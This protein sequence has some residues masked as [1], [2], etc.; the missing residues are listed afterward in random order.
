MIEYHHRVCPHCGKKIR[1]VVLS[2]LK[3]IE[4]T[5]IRVEPE[6]PESE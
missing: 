5:F 3:E 1:Y 2:T 6:E 4:G